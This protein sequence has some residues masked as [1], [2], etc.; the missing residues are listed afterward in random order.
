[1]RGDDR[2]GVKTVTDGK[3]SR[4]KEIKLRKGSCFVNATAGVDLGFR[5]VRFRGNFRWGR[6]TRIQA[7][8]R[9]S[10]LQA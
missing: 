2:R 7:V 1:M 6:D 5:D 4:G 9:F 3:G 10:Q 8:W